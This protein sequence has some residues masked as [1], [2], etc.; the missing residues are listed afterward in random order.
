MATPP[1]DLILA[2]G[3][4]IDDRFV[5]IE[6]IAILIEIGDIQLGTATQRAG[7]GLQFAE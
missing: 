6:L 2:F 1:T 3:Q 4:V 5:G 7:V